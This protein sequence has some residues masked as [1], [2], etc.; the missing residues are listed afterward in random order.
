MRPYSMDLRQRVA[1]AVDAQDGSLRQLARRFCISL[2]CISRWLALR[3]QTGSLAPRPHRSGPPPTLDEAALARLRQLVQDQ[4][5]AL[6]DELAQQLG[7]GRMTV[8][9]ALRKLKIT[10]KKKVF[11]ANER[12]RADVQQKR[13]QFQEELASLDPKRLVFVDEVGATTA[14]A[15]MYGRAPAGQRVQSNVPGQWQS[16]TLIGGLRLGGVVAPFAFAGATDTAAF[17]TYAE[18]V[19]APE[20]SPR[21][22]VIW[23]NLKPHKNP[24]VVQAVEQTGA[25]VLPAPPWSPDLIPIEK[26]FSKVKG[27]LRTLAARTR[28]SLVAAMGTALQRVGPKD[29]LG[30]FRSCGLALDRTRKRVQGLLHRFRTGGCAQPTCEPL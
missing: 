13:Q 20:L 24:G 12:E 25:R 11:Y 21:D 3:R 23:D 15:R 2:S 17:Q 16:L 28:E 6:L 1:Q 10:R 27:A 18:R 9:R 14:M 8:W 4:P 5:D 26:M 30:W 19:L 22:V 29:I 7:C